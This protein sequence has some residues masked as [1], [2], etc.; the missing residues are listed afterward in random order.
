MALPVAAPEVGAEKLM[1]KDQNIT[2][3]FAS[4]FSPRSNIV[5]SSLSTLN[6]QLSTVNLRFPHQSPS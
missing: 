5:L 3:R 4:N 6:F 1:P 2:A